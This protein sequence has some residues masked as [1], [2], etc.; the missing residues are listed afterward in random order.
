MTFAEL[1][2]AIRTWALWNLDKA[3]GV[4]LVTLIIAVIV[5]DSIFNVRFTNSIQVHSKTLYRSISSFM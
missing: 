5:G 3:V 1:V 4:G 2:L